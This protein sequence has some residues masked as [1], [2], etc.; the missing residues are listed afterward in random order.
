MEVSEKS[1]I[2]IIKKIAKE[3]REAKMTEKDITEA[4]AGLDPEINK[5]TGE[6]D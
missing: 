5:L 1:G 3:I 2:G 4:I 6:P